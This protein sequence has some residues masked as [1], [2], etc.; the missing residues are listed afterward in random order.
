MN[1]YTYLPKATVG[2][3][4][5][6]F[7]ATKM[8]EILTKMQSMFGIL[9]DGSPVVKSKMHKAGIARRFIRCPSKRSR[10]TPL[11]LASVAI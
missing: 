5:M 8:I 6:R 9:P 2:S 11:P 7:A 10:N 4:T 1:M 3:L